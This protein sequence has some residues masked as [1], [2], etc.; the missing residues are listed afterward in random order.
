MIGD[1]PDGQLELPWWTRRA[2]SVWCLHG[3]D[4]TIEGAI[5]SNPLRNL[6][7]RACICYLES[8]FTTFWWY[9]RLQITHNIRNIVHHCDRWFS[10]LRSPVEEK[11]RLV[12]F[13]QL[14]EF[15]IL[16]PSANGALVCRQFQLGT[17]A[18]LDDR[19]LRDLSNSVNFFASLSQDHHFRCFHH[20]H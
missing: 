3:P 4:S 6:S 16:L 19:D 14:R 2:S 5:E 9:F 15:P 7:R 8:Y 1:P 12:M 11:A 20:H 13:D 17:V 10:L 18:V